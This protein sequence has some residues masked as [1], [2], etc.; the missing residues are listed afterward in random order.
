MPVV[1]KCADDPPYA[2][3]IMGSDWNGYDKD[4]GTTIMYTCPF[5]SANSGGQKSKTHITVK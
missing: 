5:G 4:L 2:S 3:S 1:K